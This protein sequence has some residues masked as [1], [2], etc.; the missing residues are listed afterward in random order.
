MNKFVP[1]EKLSKR[2]KRELQEKNRGTWGPINPTTRK[3][4][5]PK[6]YNRKK[7]RSKFDESDGGVLFVSTK[8]RAQ[9]SEQCRQIERIPVSLRANRTAA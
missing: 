9:W 8:H 5:N 3:P 1:F 6:A 4:P 7:A 2:A